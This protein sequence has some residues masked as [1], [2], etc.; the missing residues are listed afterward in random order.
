MARDAMR[1]RRR[2]KPTEVEAMAKINMR[3]MKAKEA[4]RRR[5][6]PKPRRFGTR[7][8]GRRNVMSMREPGKIRMKAGKKE[9]MASTMEK[10]GE[11]KVGEA[12]AMA[13]GTK[14]NGDRRGHSHTLFARHEVPTH[15]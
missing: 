8:L 3:D 6:R 12:A 11:K 14:T 2:P 13:A 5:R 10:V 4:R 1:R 15:E 9:L 7:R